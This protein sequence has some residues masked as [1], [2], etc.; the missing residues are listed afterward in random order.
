MQHQLSKLISEKHLIGIYIIF[1]FQKWG[2]SWP[3]LVPKCLRPCPRP[4]ARDPALASAHLKHPWPPVC[5][6]LPSLSQ[7]DHLKSTISDLLRK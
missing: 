5:P 2:G 7:A 1:S 3:L 4:A 6:F